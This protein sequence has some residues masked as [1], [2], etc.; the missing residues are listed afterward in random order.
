MKRKNVNVPIK[1]NSPNDII[2]S[3]DCVIWSHA[4]VSYIKWSNDYKWRNEVKWAANQRL[5]A[6]K[7]SHK[8]NLFLK[9]CLVA[10]ASMA[11]NNLPEPWIITKE[12]HFWSASN[13]LYEFI[14]S[15]TQGR[16]IECNSTTQTIQWQYKKWFST[17]YCHEHFH[18]ERWKYK[19]L[20]GNQRKKWNVHIS[21]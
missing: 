18:T 2:S 10:P 4:N 14:F 8:Q 7:L 1:I 17:I 9:G 20:K 11:A 15:P 13:K 6:V 21:K 16:Y 19:Q 5:N 12:M 3:E